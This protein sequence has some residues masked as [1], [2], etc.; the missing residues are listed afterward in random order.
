MR[1]WLL[2]ATDCSCSSL[3]VCALF[4]TEDTPQARGQYALAITHA[5]A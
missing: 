2:T 1:T 3:D 4:A 5:P